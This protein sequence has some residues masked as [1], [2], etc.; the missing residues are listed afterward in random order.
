MLNYSCLGEI[1][2]T[3]FNYYF[4]VLT[5]E[6]CNNYYEWYYMYEFEGEKVFEEDFKIQCAKVI[7]DMTEFN[8]CMAE[9]SDEDALKDMNGK[10][11]TYLTSAG[12]ESTFAPF[13]KVDN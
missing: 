13:G 11:K 7:P 2:F 1:K 10:L 4:E 8:T 3:S 9:V 12:K 5:D 6:D